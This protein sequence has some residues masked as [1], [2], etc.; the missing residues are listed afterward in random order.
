MARGGVHAF[1]IWNEPNTTFWA[2]RP[3]PG[4]YTKLLRSASR[5]IHRADRR[6]TV[7]SGG[8][9]AQ[10]P[11][12]DWVADDGTGMSPLH[13]LQ[14]MYAHGAHGAFDALG[15]HPYGIPGGPRGR[16][17]E[18][19]RPDARAARRDAGERRRR[20]VDLGN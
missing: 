3:D 15:F 5:A 11:T 7:V 12:L 14:A 13:F 20:S 17:L 16:R 6:A 10:G 8:L 19:I 18:R 4:V 9:A 1:E 2:P